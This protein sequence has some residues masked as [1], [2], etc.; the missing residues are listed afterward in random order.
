MSAFIRFKA[1]REQIGEI[2]AKAFEASAPMGMGWMNFD[3]NEVID[4]RK[5]VPEEGANLSLDYVSGRMVKL[6]I[7]NE[8]DGV[9]KT[10]SRAS[11]D[12]QSWLSRFSSPLDL[13]QSVPGVEIL[14]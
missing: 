6:N 8:G 13:I 5:F 2:A 1:T 10:N 3:A 7:R 14:K 4:A 11:Y 12:Y 9:W